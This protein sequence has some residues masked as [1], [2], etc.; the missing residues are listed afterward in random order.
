[1]A[2]PI[3]VHRGLRK[4]GCAT[5]LNELLDAAPEDF[6]RCVRLRNRRVDLAAIADEHLPQD[7]RHR[8]FLM[9]MARPHPRLA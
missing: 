2:L 9:L 7:L 5:G 8:M 4:W 3:I 1:V 6:R